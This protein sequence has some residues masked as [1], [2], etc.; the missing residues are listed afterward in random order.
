MD[1]AL[2]P[3]AHHLGGA[4]AEDTLGGGRDVMGNEIGTDAADH[5]EAI[6]GEQAKGGVELARR[7]SPAGP[8]AAQE[9]SEKIHHAAP[10]LTAAGFVPVKMIGAIRVAG[11][12]C[13]SGTRFVR[14]Q[15]PADQVPVARR[16]GSNSPPR[17]S[18]G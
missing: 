14:R 4:P 2:G 6:F 7:R 15:E 17:S 18:I 8:P 16:L 5:V 10:I 9:I 13:D 12:F 11:P 3:D 1:E